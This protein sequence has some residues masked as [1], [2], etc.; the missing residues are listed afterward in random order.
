MDGS[1]NVSSR[2]PCPRISSIRPSRRYMWVFTASSHPNLLTDSTEVQVGWDTII[3]G[4]REY[5]KTAL[6][7]HLE[8][9]EEVDDYATKGAIDFEWK[10]TFSLFALNKQYHIEIAGTRFHRPK[11]NI[12]RGRMIVQRCDTNVGAMYRSNLKLGKISADLKS[13][14]DPCVNAIV[15]EVD[16]QVA[17]CANNVRVGYSCS[18]SICGLCV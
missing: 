17:S 8:D 9:R 14:F 5:L 11:M 16:K 10:R 2:Y 12:R 1:C 3:D 13:S 18:V 7:N 6:G 15:K 4:V